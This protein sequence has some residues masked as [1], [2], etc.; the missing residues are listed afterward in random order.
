MVAGSGFETVG[1]QGQDQDS[2]DEQGVSRE[3]RQG[4]REQSQGIKLIQFLVFWLISEKKCC[5]IYS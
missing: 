2:G 3:E 5:F 1:L 4:E